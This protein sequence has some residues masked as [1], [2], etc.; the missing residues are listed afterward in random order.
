MGNLDVV[1]EYLQL[2]SEWRYERGINDPSIGELKATIASESERNSLSVDQ[3]TR[4]QCLIKNIEHAQAG[5]LV[6]FA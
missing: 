6:R 3:K 4:L 5:L 1:T 2:F